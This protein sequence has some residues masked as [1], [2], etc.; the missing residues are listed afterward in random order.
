M[1]NK[2]SKALMNRITES[3]PNAWEYLSKAMNVSPREVM[4]QVEKRQVERHFAIKAVLDGLRR[5]AEREAIKR[6]ALTGGL[7]HDSTG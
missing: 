1:K 7:D 5:E 6:Y 3:I 2:I 4:D